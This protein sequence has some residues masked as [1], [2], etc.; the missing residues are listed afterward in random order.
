MTDFRLTQYRQVA[1]LLSSIENLEGSIDNIIQT[2]ANTCLK[3]RA[4]ASIC[5]NHGISTNALFKGIDMHEFLSNQAYR[6]ALRIDSSDISRVSAVSALNSTCVYIALQAAGNQQVNSDLVLAAHRLFMQN[7]D[8]FKA[9]IVNE[10]MMQEIQLDTMR[11]ENVNK[12]Q[13]DIT[14]R[15]TYITLAGVIITALLAIVNIVVSIM[16]PK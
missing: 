14:I 8:V 9:E 4:V 1:D 7:Y 12:K 13:L 3:L 6:A 10:K 5:D 11:F 2:C 16:I 15:N